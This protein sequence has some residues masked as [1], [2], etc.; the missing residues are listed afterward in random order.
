MTVNQFVSYIAQHYPS[1]VLNP[2]FGLPGT[3]GGAVVNNSESFGL[4]FGDIVQ[5]VDIIDGS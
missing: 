5:S 3:V 4:T 1:N 2:R